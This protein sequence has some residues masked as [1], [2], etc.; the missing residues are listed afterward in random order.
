MEKISELF[1][2]QHE[3]MALVSTSYNAGIYKNLELYRAPVA[4][5]AFLNAKTD[6]ARILILAM[7]DE[8]HE[9]L[10]ELNWKPWK[11]TKKEVDFEKVG[12]EIADCWHFLLELTM[13]FNLEE[14]LPRLMAASFAKNHARLKAGY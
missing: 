7:T 10:R 13:L 3:Y 2:A 5:A 8:L 6:E 12:G 9:V 1:S 14:K 11:Q 4:K